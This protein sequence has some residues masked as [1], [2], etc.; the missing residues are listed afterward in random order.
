V[1]G[2]LLPANTN[3][4]LL[5]TLGEPRFALDLAVVERVVQAV[6]VL[7]LPKAPPLVL[8]VINVQGQ[9]IPVVD[10]RQCFGMPARDITVNDQF[11]LARTSKRRVAVVTD[12]VS[13]ILDLADGQLVTADQVLPGAAFIRG[14]A[15]LDDKLVLI[16][17]LDQILSLETERVLDVNATE[18][19][20]V[21][22]FDD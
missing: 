17:D 11:I 12:A 22:A 6:E 21:M 16:C 9:V 14:V 13:G 18:E 19:W 5:F 1:T 8:G 2:S 20:P 10:I 3:Q 15:K 4:I 7:P